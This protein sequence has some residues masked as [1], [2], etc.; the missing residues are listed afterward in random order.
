M[1]DLFIGQE[2]GENCG[3]CVVLMILAHFNRPMRFFFAS[4]KGTSPRKILNRL[5]R[6]GLDAKPKTINIRNLKPWS[7]LWYP[8]RGKK[9]KRG[10]HYAIFIRAENGKYFVYDSV[11]DGP[12]WLEESELKK[13]WYKTYHKR[14]CGWVIEIRDPNG[15]V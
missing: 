6:V 12:C 4:D 14:W 2:D 13:K 1:P 7:I 8:T 10:D 11:K 9:G 5:R 15:R 3:P